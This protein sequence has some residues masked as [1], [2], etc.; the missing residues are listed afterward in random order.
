MQE[1]TLLDQEVLKSE[2][3]AIMQLIFISDTSRNKVP[4]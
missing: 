1:N 3:D 2:V 4:I